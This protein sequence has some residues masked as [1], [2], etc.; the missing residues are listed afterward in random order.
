MLKLVKIGKDSVVYRKIPTI[1][2][3]MKWLDIKIILIL[4]K[5]VSF[6]ASLLSSYQNKVSFRIN[7]KYVATAMTTIKPKY[8]KVKKKQK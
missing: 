3:I 2:Y 8:P 1:V 7:K 4:R 5:M 6:M